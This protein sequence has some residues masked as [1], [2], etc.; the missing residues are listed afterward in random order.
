MIRK[1]I[2]IKA[3]VAETEA[4]ITVVSL[5][6]PLEGAATAAFAVDVGVAEVVIELEVGGLCVDDEGVELGVGADEL[7]SEEVEVVEEAD[8]ELVEEPAVGKLMTDREMVVVSSAEVEVEVEVGVLT[9]VRG[10]RVVVRTS[11]DSDRDGLSVDLGADVVVLAGAEISVARGRSLLVWAR[12]FLGLS[13]GLPGVRDGGRSSSV[14][15]GLDPPCSKLAVSATMSSTDDTMGMSSA[16]RFFR[17]G[18]LR[19]RRRPF[20]E[21]AFP[22]AGR[23]APGIGRIGIAGDEFLRKIQ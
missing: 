6:S 23:P 17:T 15:V 22:L 8:D 7:D 11:S 10:S 13:S 12:S 19:T 4:T 1:M 20:G 18:S 14:G 2:V 5:I 16:W 3:T 21:C 9:G